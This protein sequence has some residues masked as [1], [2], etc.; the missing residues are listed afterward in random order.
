MLTITELRNEQ[1]TNILDGLERIETVPIT[2]GITRDGKI[3]ARTRD[4]RATGSSYRDALAKLIQLEI[5]K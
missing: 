3:F 2:M 1:S 5:T 4:H